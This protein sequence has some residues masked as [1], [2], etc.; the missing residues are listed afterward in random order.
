MCLKY[1]HTENNIFALCVYNHYSISIPSTGIGGVENDCMV[2][3]GVV[4]AVVETVVDGVLVVG[5]VVDIVFVFV[6]VVTVID[7]FSKSNNKF[8]LYLNI[9]IRKKNLCNVLFHVSVFTN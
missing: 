3:I 7:D 9:L 6:V 5:I 1:H 2:I 8:V 4:V